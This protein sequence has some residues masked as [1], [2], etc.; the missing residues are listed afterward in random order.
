MVSCVCSEMVFCIPWL[1]M[2]QQKRTH[3]QPA[4]NNGLDLYPSICTQCYRHFLLFGELHFCTAL[5]FLSTWGK[6]NTHKSH[7]S[8]FK[9]YR[10][11][12][13]SVCCGHGHHRHVPP[14]RKHQKLFI[15]LILFKT[16]SFT[17]NSLFTDGLITV[18]FTA[19]LLCRNWK[20]HLNIC[21]LQHFHFTF[22]L[23]EDLPLPPWVM[24]VPDLSPHFSPPPA[25]LKDQSA[26]SVILRL[27]QS[28]YSWERYCTQSLGEK[29]LPEFYCS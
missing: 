27:N 18:L 23:S 11:H 7:V 13:T 28:H 15:A 17:V 16:F 22:L 10:D 6:I 14:T 5:Q 3:L 1:P 24:G 21:T 8:C 9:H 20:K 12:K 4:R 19:L 2:L 29:L 25:F 26:F